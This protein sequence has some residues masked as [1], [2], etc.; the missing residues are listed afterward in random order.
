MLHKLLLRSSLVNMQT[1]YK[2]HF[3]TIVYAKFGVA[4]RAHNGE[5]ENRECEIVTQSEI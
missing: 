5:L 1:S 4:N 2:E 3:R